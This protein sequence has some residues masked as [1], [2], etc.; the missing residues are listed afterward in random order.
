MNVFLTHVHHLE[1]N[2]V[3]IWTMLTNANVMKDSVVNFAKQTSMNVRHHLVLMEELVSIK[4]IV[5]D[6]IVRL[7]GMDLDVK[8]M[9]ECVIHHHVII[10]LDVL[11]YFRFDFSIVK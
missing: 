7:D 10:M 6:V 8:K 1:L 9:L 2:V 4:S 11:I 3:S 5:I